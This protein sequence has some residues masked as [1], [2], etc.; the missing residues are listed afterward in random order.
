V[1][2][3]RP[4]ALECGFGTFVDMQSIRP[5][6]GF[7]YKGPGK[8]AQYIT[9]YMTRDVSAPENKGVRMVTYLG[10]A[11]VA[12]TRFGWS[13]GMSYLY[14]KGQG[15]YVDLYGFRPKFHEYWFVIRLGWECC[16]E[17][18]QDYLIMS[19]KAIRRWWEAAAYPDDP[20]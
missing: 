19:D 8:V 10:G 14:R 13:R 5:S 1:Q 20:F 17:D 2:L 16:G 6:N 12:S 4:A 9:R 15:M 18:E 3:V 11:R 7:H